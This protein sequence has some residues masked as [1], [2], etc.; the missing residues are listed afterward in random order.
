MT[1][2]AAR[3]KT[4]KPMGVIYIAGSPLPSQVLCQAGSAWSSNASSKTFPTGPKFHT[5]ISPSQQHCNDI[6]NHKP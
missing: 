3:L 2:R 6:S 4:T 1:L 5:G